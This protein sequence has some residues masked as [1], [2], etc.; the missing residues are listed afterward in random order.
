MFGWFCRRKKKCCEQK[1]SADVDIHARPLTDFAKGASVIVV[2]NGDRKT[3][4]MGV[5][6]GAPVT[7]IKNRPHDANMVIAT[8]ESRYIISKE[9]AQKIRVH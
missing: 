1:C 6:S 2:S 5:F 7:V 9:S 4:E 3:L 8:G